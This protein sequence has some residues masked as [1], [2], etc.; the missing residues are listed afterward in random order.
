MKSLACV[1]AE[2]GSQKELQS[3]GLRE[4]VA[5]AVAT[6]E[7]RRHAGCQGRRRKMWG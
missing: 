7:G 1:K 3:R 2:N 6:K 4:A 5:V